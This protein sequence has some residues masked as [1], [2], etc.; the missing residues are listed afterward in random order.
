L[1]R[2][3]V[4]RVFRAFYHYRCALQRGACEE[5]VTL[6]LEHAELLGLVK[7]QRKQHRERQP[8]E[9]II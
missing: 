7:R 3:S 2:I 1:E 9:S 6:L 5:L 8:R 4:E